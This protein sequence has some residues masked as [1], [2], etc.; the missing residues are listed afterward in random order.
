MKPF[1]FIYDLYDDNGVS[2]IELPVL[3]SVG[4]I[5]VCEF[6]T[7]KVIKPPSF[8]PKSYKNVMCERIEKL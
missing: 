6:G 5:F 2:S 1:D 3:I 4:S 8:V 7:Y